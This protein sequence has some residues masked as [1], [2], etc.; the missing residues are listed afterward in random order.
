MGAGPMTCPS[1]AE[2]NQGMR[3]KVVIAEKIGN[4][5]RNR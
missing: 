5:A 2:V 1:L 3:G 4:Y